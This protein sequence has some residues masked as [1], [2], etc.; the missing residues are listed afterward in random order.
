MLA[1]GCCLPTGMATVQSEGCETSPCSALRSVSVCVGVCVL[2]HYAPSLHLAG[3]DAQD[4]AYLQQ[5]SG[6]DRWAVEVHSKPYTEAFPNEDLV[7]LAAESD[8]VLTKLDPSKVRVHCNVPMHWVAAHQAI[9]NHHL[10]VV[11]LCIEPG[12]RNWCFC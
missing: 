12:I 11:L 6:F 2:T 4:L 3:V 9:L 1:W 8:T 7:Y 10:A 5:L